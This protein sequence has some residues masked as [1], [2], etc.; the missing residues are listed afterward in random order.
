[1][2]RLLSIL[3]VATMMF[4]FMVP[5]AFAAGGPTASVTSASAKVGETVTVTISI[6]GLN[7]AVTNAELKVSADSALKLIALEPA[8]LPGSVI[9]NPT[10]GKV[11][12]AHT[13]PVS[14][15]TLAVATFRVDANAASGDYYVYATVSGMRNGQGQRVS[16]NSGVGKITVHAHAATGGWLNNAS[17]HW[18]KC[19]CGQEMDKALHIPGPAATYESAQICTICGYVIAPALPAPHE[20]VWGAWA[21][22]SE[23]QHMRVCATDSTHVDYA[24][25]NFVD[26]VCADCGY[27]LEIIIPE[28]PEDLDSLTAEELIL[29]MMLMG[30]RTNTITATAGEGGTITPAGATKVPFG[31]NQTYVITPMPGYEIDTVVVDG[32]DKGAISEYTFNRVLSKHT[33][34][35]TFKR[36]AWVNPFRD[37]KAA[38]W[39]YSDVAYVNSVGLMIGTS[40][41]EFSPMATATRAQI[42]TTLWRLEGQPVAKTNHSFTD[43]ENGMWYTDA[44]A[45]AAENKIVDGYGD[46]IFAPGDAIT[47][48]QIVAILHRYADYKGIAEEVSAENPSAYEYSEWAKENVAW[49]HE[50]GI[51]AG[52]GMDITDL[53]EDATRAEI[54]AYL[55]RFC[56]QILA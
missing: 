56:L 45:W 40:S 33:I 3:L 4:T 48:E 43:V 10:S 26:N 37:V 23:V 11:I 51:F 25:H 31:R 2:K 20:H 42:V 50:N 21:P 28:T 41:D 15:S 36:I 55:A 8:N 19:S 32:K 22:Y 49:A 47:R 38:D 53:S 35:A 14:V 27:V 44:I 39:F 5:A 7:E 12:F 18:H 16:V 1:M 6:N 13:D 9:A 29:I 34:T 24:N 52:I 17:Y 54:A 30:N 46:G